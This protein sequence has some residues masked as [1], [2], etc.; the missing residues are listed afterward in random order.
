[1]DAMIRAIKAS[2]LAPGVT[3]MTVPGEPEFEL[4]ARRRREGIPLVVGVL[5]QL[6]ELAASLGVEGRL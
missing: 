6:N 5:D 1:M 4:E 3:K 2:E